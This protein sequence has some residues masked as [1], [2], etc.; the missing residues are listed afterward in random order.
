MKKENATLDF[1]KLEHEMLNAW[2]EEKLFNKIVDKNKNSEKRFRFLDGP[3]TANNKLGVHHFWGRVLKDATIKY[4]SMIG[5]SQQFQNGFDAQGMWVEVETEKELG[6]KGKPEILAYGMDKFTE[7]CI[8]RVKYFGEEITKQSIRMGQ[9]MDWDNSYYTNTDENITSIWHFLKVCSDKGWL[10][11]KYRP[12]AWCPRCGTSL[13]EHELSSSYGEVTHTAIFFKVPVKNADFKMV[14]WTT[15]PWTLTANCALAVNPD[16]TYV[17]V[18]FE[19]EKLVFGKDSLKILKGDAEILEEFKGDKLVG[20]E[21]ETMFP[22]LE[23][24]QFPHK[25]YAWDQVLAGEGSCVVHIAPGC[26]IEDFE[27]GVE[28][29]IPAICPIDEQGVMLPS[30]GFIAGKKTT[31]VVEDVVNRLK[32]DNKLLYSH[33]YKH[34]YAHCWRCKTDIVYKLISTWYIKM[35][36]IRPKLIEAIQDVDFQPSYA[37]KRMEDWLNNMGDWNISRS[38]FYGLPL[39]IYQCERCGKVHVIG[40]LDELRQKA[41]NKEDLD[42]IPHLHRPYIDKIKIKCECGEELSRIP[43]VGDCWLDAGITPFS[44]KK[45]FTDREYFNKNFPNAFVCE[46]IEQIKLWFYSLLVMSVV[47]TGKAPYEKVVTYQYVKSETGEEFHKSGGNSLEAEKVADE[48]GAEA[49]RYLYASANPNNE[50]RFGYGLLEDVK[51][52][53]L[54]FWN[55]YVFFNTYAVID[56]PNL[57]DYKPDFAK[58]AI[59]DK[60][61]LESVAEFTRKSDENYAENKIYLVIKDFEK[62]ID[63]ISNFYIR[64]NRKRFW[65]SD[66]YAYYSLYFAIKNIIKVMAPVIP[67]ITDYIW[68]NLVVEIEKDEVSSVHLSEFPNI[69]SFGYAELVKDIERAREIIYLAQKLRNENKI[70]VKQPL[71]TLFLKVDEDYKKAVINLQDIIKEELNIKNIVFEDS[72]DKFNTK[73]LNINFQVAGKVLGA[74][75]KAYQQA[76][77]DAN[78]DDMK[79]Y[80][81]EFEREG[82]VTLNSLEKQSADLFTIKFLPKKEF[83]IAIENN[84]IVALDITLTEELIHEGYYR[85]ITRQIQVARKDADFKIEDRIILDLSSKN[86]EIQNVIEKYLPKIMEETLSVESKKLDKP[87]YQTTFNVAEEEVVLKISRV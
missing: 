19:G 37:K 3:A 25:I 59:T 4:H 68:K 21:Y 69:E 73:I 64:S 13:S 63:D 66:M 31:D 43:E 39:P 53:L 82:S 65:E 44:T 20:L 24:Q 28:N 23:L 72:D 74:N 15:T 67:F 77:K 71:S 49:I 45:Y 48:V 85:E 84:N 57:K 78:E 38:R 41:I 26:G 79:K 14:G 27:L 29:D 62:L 36:E 54:A 30:C 8:D 61:L 17:K 83:A 51:K 5:E 34:S 81:E 46:M 40:S 10:I 86:E 7:K 32:A 58:L 42:K 47:L 56:N 80:V 12:I 6:L 76:L 75:L 1:V 55:I 52:Q 18:L 16:L 60:W 9:F 33:K 87:E 2:Q 35:D 22:E 70:K 11:K 50:M